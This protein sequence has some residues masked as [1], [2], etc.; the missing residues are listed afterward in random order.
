MTILTLDIGGSEIK[1]AHY[2]TDGSCS[3]TLSNQKTAVSAQDNHIGEQIVRIC[4]EEQTHAALQ[5]VAIS[6]AG[7]IDPYRGTVLHAGP[8]IPGYSGP[9]S[10]KPSKAN[11]ACRAAS[12]TTSMPWR[13][14]KPG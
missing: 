5:G 12:K 10:N 3:K 13:S 1:A 7:V 2:Q 4:R 11:A 9:H 6:S 14:A 8:S